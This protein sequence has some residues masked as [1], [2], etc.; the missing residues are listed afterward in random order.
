[1]FKAGEFAFA[2]HHFWLTRR[3]MF[4]FA[5]N[6]AECHQLARTGGA[7]GLFA[8]GARGRSGAGGRGGAVVCS[9]R[10]GRLR[11]GLDSLRRTRPNGRSRFRA[12]LEKPLTSPVFHAFRHQYFLFVSPFTT[13]SVKLFKK[14]KDWGFESVEIPIEDPSHID[15][16]KVKAALDKGGLRLRLG[17]R[18]HGAGT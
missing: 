14:F 4:F 1:M 12:S 17:V 5:V 2:F 3:G 18:V 7:E 6:V 8:A 9:G 13:E 16:K 15:G 10:R 11:G